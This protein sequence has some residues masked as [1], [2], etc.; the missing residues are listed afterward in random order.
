MTGFQI[1]AIVGVVFFVV[2][3]IVYFISK[4]RG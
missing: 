2:T 3:L 4:R 1:A